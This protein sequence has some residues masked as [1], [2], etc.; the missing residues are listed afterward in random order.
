MFKM[1]AVLN[2]FDLKKTET[3]LHKALEHFD[4][5][6]TDQF[7]KEILEQISGALITLE[8]IRDKSNNLEYAERI[9]LSE[10]IFELRDNVVKT[11]KA[12]G[13]VI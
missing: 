8:L 12:E 9:A 13:G 10:Q 1:S 3:Q 5:T 11:V 4:S 6:P 7:S 2:L